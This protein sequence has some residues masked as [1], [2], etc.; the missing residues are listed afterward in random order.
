MDL[1]GV[2]DSFEVTARRLAKVGGNAQV[3]LGAQ[4]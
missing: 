3:I 4:L 1:I 2:E